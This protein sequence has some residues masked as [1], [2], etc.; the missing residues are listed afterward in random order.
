MAMSLL[1]NDKGREGELV[2]APNS[3]CRGN[4]ITHPVIRAEVSAVKEK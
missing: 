3:M 2:T 1:L 4:S